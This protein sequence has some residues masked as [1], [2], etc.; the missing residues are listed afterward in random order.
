MSSKADKAILHLFSNNGGGKGF[1]IMLNDVGD[2]AQFGKDKIDSK[3]TGKF[4][5][6]KMH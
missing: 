4:Y 2:I 6:K 5:K 1:N 3:E